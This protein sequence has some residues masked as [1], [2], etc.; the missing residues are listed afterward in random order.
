M[1][2]LFERVLYYLEGNETETQNWQTADGIKTVEFHSFGP[3]RWIESVHKQSRMTCIECLAMILFAVDTSLHSPEPA[4]RIV[5]AWAVE[6]RKAVS[7]GEIQARDPV[8]LLALPTLPDG[9]D[10]V[11]S[12]ADADKF[13][14][15]R[16]MEWRF[17]EIALHLFNECEQA[18]QKRHFP[19]WTW[20]T[21]HPAP[22]QNTATPAPAEETKEPEYSG[23]T[24]SERKERARAINRATQAQWD[25]IN[26]GRAKEVQTAA[27]QDTEENNYW[28]TLPSLIADKKQEITD[29]ELMRAVS[30]SEAQIK[31]EKL[32]SLRVE[33]E[34]LKK[35]TVQPQDN[36]N[37]E[38]VGKTVV[39]AREAG[40]RSR[41]WHLARRRPIVPRFAHT[42]ELRYFFWNGGGRFFGTS[43]T[44]RPHVLPFAE[45]IPL[46][47]KIKINKRPSLTRWVFFIQCNHDCASEATDRCKGAKTAEWW[48]SL[49]LA[50]RYKTLYRSL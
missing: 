27:Q 37:L 46:W 8:T 29:W 39:C 19:P 16:G 10:W 40:G 1:T 47:G 50:T 33:L 17:G 49:A 32:A 26:N 18:I 42:R 11:L 9:L 15:S 5:E 6:L 28:F 44:P 21:K 4:R 20:E 2:G 14:V 38:L 43:P 35:P 41:L 13:I 36:A 7:T 3:D 48:H 23:L 45:K 22:E 25:R 31:S 24:D 34:L 12:M 30:I